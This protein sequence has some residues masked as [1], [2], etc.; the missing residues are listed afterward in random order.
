MFD[1]IRNWTL[2]IAI[3]AGIA[4][5][6]IYV[7][8][9]PLNSSDTRHAVMSVISVVQPTLIFLM[10]FITFCKQRP[11]D[12]K[13]ARWH[14][15]ALLMQIAVFALCVL[16]QRSMSNAQCSMILECAMLCFICPTATAAAVVTSRL[17]GNT[18]TL[19]TYT[20]LINLMAAIAIP[21]VVPLLHPGNGEWSMFGVQC[22]ILAK[23][24]PLL[25]GPLLLAIVLR[26]V[27]PKVTE[28][29]ARRAGVAFYLWAV[30]L[31]IAI[32][33]S[34]KAFVHSRAPLAL[35]LSIA[36]VSAVACIAQFAFGRYIGRRYGDTV[37]ATQG[38]GQKNT[39]L[40]I[41]LG[42]TFFN[43]LTALAGGFYSIWHNLYNSWQIHRSRKP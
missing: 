7:T 14:L 9:P 15:P 24:F 13:L 25:I 40:A 42:Y 18:G 22:S 31:A 28:A 29:I 35:L 6:F 33:V 10:L 17:G 11:H 30:S 19:T 41:W 27:L 16:V 3:V 26:A 12:L 21:I 32:A 5:Y 20:I 23:V 43:P 39:V 2:P 1:F 37:S 36:V 34:V 4:S 38:C 8:I